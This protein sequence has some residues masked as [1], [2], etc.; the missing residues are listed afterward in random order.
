M[1]K[2]YV[3]IGFLLIMHGTIAA[4]TTQPLTLQKAIKTAVANNR[5]VGIAKLDEQ[6]A[7][8]KYKETNAIYLPQ[9]SFSY[10]AL[11]TNNP[12]NAFG[13]K[14]QQKTIGAA[15]FDP[16]QLNHPTATPDFVTKIDLHQ[17]LINMDMVYMRNA[18][19]KQTEIYK[20]KTQRTEE[21]ISFEVEKA[22]LQLSFAYKA[23]AVLNESLATAKQINEFTTNNFKQGLVQKSDVLNT[24]VYIAKVESNILKTQSNIATA[25][26]FLSILMGTKTGTLYTVE[27]VNN[28]NHNSSKTVSAQL[29]D[30]M[31]MQ[32]AIEAS[33]IMIQSSK[34]SY[35][36]KLNAFGSYQFNDASMFG[37]S[38]NAYLAGIQLSWNIF[39]G[40]KTKNTI[41]TQTIERNKITQEL[42][43]QKE[44][45][46]LEVA[47]N[48]RDID[49]ANATILQ[50]NKAIEKATEAL[51]IVQDRYKQGLVNTIDVLTAS[52][53]L[54]Q[55]K[56]NLQQTTLE[57]H[58]AQAY[59]QLL[60]ASNTK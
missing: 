58:V 23:M 2:L 24:E 7:T 15:D 45:S 35:L 5:S 42:E 6:I 55:Q 4:Q 54:S 3:S 31:A 46:T 9:L 53:Q 21:Y 11:T 51:R 48:L 57:L 18:A 52:N 10:T 38:A 17:P 34:K 47:K 44:Q 13:F 56:L 27:D 60:T 49:V 37:F 59:L 30:F 29:A 19:K 39:K 14:L 28:S 33:D 8:A 16:N 40:N 25:S 20:Y 43:Q 32:K 50:H 22:Y 41:A 1:I 36:P 12:L 26:D